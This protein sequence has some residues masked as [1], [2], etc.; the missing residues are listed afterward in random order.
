MSFNDGMMSWHYTLRYWSEAA[1]IVDDPARPARIAVTSAPWQN[2]DSW[3]DYA[4]LGRH[5]QNQLVYVP[6]TASG[7]IGHF[8]GTE[9]YQQGADFEAW[10]RRLQDGRIGYVMSFWPTSI[11][12]RWMRGHPE[13]F[14][15]VS[16]AKTWGCFRVIGENASAP[17]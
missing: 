3:L 12:L 15:E 11:E 1:R 7:K 14:E 5:F 6:I 2:H 17:E 8:D 9:A 13:Q 10:H 16:A 4:F